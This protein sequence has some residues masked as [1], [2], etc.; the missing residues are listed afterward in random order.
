MGLKHRLWLVLIG[1]L[2]ATTP[3]LSAQAPAAETIQQRVT[4]SG[5]RSPTMDLQ[6]S[7]QGMGDIKVVQEFPKP[8]MF[9][10]AAS[11]EFYYTDNVFYTHANPLGSSAYAGSY[12]GSFV[13]YSLRDWTPR[14]S[15]QYNM[16]RYDTVPAGDFDNEQV[17]ATSTYIFGD[18]RNWSWISA[19]VLSRYTAPHQNDREFY[20]E[21]IYGN[22]VR[23]VEPLGD[24][25]PLFLI[26]AYD[27]AYHQASPATF[28]YLSNGAI[29]AL[30]YYPINAITISPYLNPS[31]R[32]FFTNT[33]TQNDR[34]DL[35]LAE[36][37][38]VNWQP[39]KY[40]SLGADLYHVNDFSNNSGLSFNYTIPGV[41]L[42]G[43]FKF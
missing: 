39:Y 2:L 23:H 31:W 4:I 25:M 32:R 3:R 8:E 28:D 13:P 21:A 24:N 1:C 11:Q 22:Q 5:L 36:G 7:S 17:A 42:T 30:A 26:A 37:L 10:F 29:L 14:I 18:D 16:F 40:V 9:T 38:N 34:D 33:S 35:H 27:L 12:T 15:V 6:A 41:I 43:E 19:A 20:R